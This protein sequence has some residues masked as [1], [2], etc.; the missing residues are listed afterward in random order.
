MELQE[1]IERLKGMG[2]E[3]VEEDE[4]QLD[5]AMS[6]VQWHIHNLTNLDSIPT[7]L[8]YIA[9]DMVC[10]EFLQMKKG[11]GQLSEIEFEQIANSVSMGD[12]SVS[13][14]TDATPEQKFD[15]VIAYLLTGHDEDI[16]CYRKMVW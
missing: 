13:F 2:Y 8:K 6:K 9:I 11:L 1:I 4:Y 7:G 15:I 16:I 5:F 10:A 12:T 14:V 3:Y